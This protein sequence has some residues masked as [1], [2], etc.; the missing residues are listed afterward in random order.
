MISSNQYERLNEYHTKTEPVLELFRRKE[1]I[2]AVDG[3]KSVA[4]FRKS[5]AS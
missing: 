2:V 5:C 1:K 3:T 4:Q